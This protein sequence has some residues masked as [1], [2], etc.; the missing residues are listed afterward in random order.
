MH[1][2]ELSQHMHTVYLNLWGRNKSSW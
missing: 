1:S 2:E